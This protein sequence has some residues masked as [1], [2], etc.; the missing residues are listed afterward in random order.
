[1]NTHKSELTPEELTNLKTGDAKSYAAGMGAVINSMKHIQRESGM[2]HGTKVLA[3]LNQKNGY[4]CPSCAWPDPDDHRAITEFCENG[5]KA[6]A[7]ESTRKTIEPSFFRQ[8]SIQEIGSKSDYWHELQ[9]R[10]VSPMILKKGSN[11]YEALS[12]DEAF[13]VIANEFQ[14]L[15]DPNDAIFYTSGR[16]SNEAAFAYQLLARMFGTNNLPDCSNMCHESSGV[17]LNNTIGIGKGT[18]TLQDFDHSEMVFVIGQNPGTNHPRMLSALQNCVRNGGT[19]ISVNPLREAGLLGF[20]HPQE[21][22]GIAGKYTPL[23]STYLQVKPNGDHALLKG[24]AKHLIETDQVDH[25][26]IGEYCVGYTHYK[27]DILSED[28]GTLSSLSGIGKDKIIEVADQFAK[29]KSAIFCWAMGLTQHKNAVPTIEEIVNLQLLTGNLGKK[30]SG[31]CPVRGHSNV[32]GDRTMG[33]FEKMPES[34]LEQLESVFQSPIPRRPGYDTVDAIQAM[35]NEKGKIFFG[36]GGNFL[37]ATP[38]TEYT[39]KALRNCRLTVHVST[40]LNRSHVITGEQAII[41][42]CLGRSEIDSTQKGA[43]FITVENSMGIVHKSQGRFRPISENLKGEP[44]IVCSLGEKLF[45]QQL[46]WTEWKEDYNEIRNAV[47]KV[48]PGFSNFNERVENPGGFYLPNHVKDRDFSSTGGTIPF[49]INSIE[50]LRIKDDQLI[51]MTIRSHDQFNTTIYGM[52]DRYRG[53]YNE[54]R[55]ILLNPEDM[56]ERNIHHEEPVNITSFF[57]GETRSANLFLAIKYDIPRGCAA[58]YFPE[59]NVLVPIQSVA[60]QS[61]T[62]TSKGIVITVNPARLNKKDSKAT[63]S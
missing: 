39:A 20:A 55:I 22:S 9:G 23:T 51:L 44:N 34:F 19:I 57:N 21:V 49:S 15:P 36:L 54:R 25:S 38:D 2:I 8:Y 50:Q 12:W 62:P 32:Q 11:H 5:A 33:V 10:L 24:I 45:P 18:V 26:F 7:S 53:I 63:H 52:N 16:A 48:I 3:K 35:H 40:K 59:A 1:M 17:A 29:S 41:L 30:S 58:A 6:I 60:D 47:E 43:Q 4:D 14:G 13:S 37:S 61:N 56:K 28:W 31:L 42:P 27:D 46:F